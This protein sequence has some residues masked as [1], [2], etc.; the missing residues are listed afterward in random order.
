V[1]VCVCV[2][3]VV[4]EMKS[5]GENDVERFAIFAHHVQSCRDNADTYK[6]RLEYVQSLFEAV[7]FYLLC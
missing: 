4:Q 2:C 3:D 1:C 7:V 6:Q 5:Q